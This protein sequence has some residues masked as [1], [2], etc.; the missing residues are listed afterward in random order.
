MM[1]VGLDVNHDRRNTQ[2]TIG[3]AASFDR[4][5]VKYFTMT[6]YQELAQDMIKDLDKHIAKCLDNFK[7]M[8]T[9][10]PKSI[11]IWR[12][13]VSATQIET[14]IHKE[15]VTIK[16]GIKSYYDKHAAQGVRPNFA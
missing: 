11:L 8:N 7:A 4:N 5:F 2:S 10:L 3:I 16:N 6:D 12:D 15:V 13:G 9:C 1:L 14:L